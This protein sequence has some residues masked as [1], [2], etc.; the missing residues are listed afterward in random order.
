[1]LLYN[2][3]IKTIGDKIPPVRW[4][5]GMGQDIADNPCRRIS[6]ACWTFVLYHDIVVWSKLDVPGKS[7]EY[8]L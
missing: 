7:M 8:V 4:Y 3:H 6:L 1:M 2:L 5:Y